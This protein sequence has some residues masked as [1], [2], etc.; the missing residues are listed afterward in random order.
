MPKTGA[1]NPMRILEGS[2][3]LERQEAGLHEAARAALRGWRAPPPG[4]WPSLRW[5]LTLAPLRGLLRGGRRAAAL[6]IDAARYAQGRAGEEALAQV[7]GQ[8]LDD[9]YILLRNYLPPKSAGY[10]GD[11]DGVLVGPPGVI[12]F[13]VKTW[14]GYYRYSGEEWLFRPHPQAGWQPAEKNPTTQARNNAKR[15]ERTLAAAGLGGGHPRIAVRPVI[16]LAGRAAYV[17]VQRP[18]VVPLF[19]LSDRKPEVS[20][21]EQRVLSEATVA[22]VAEALARV[23]RPD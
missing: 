3:Y 11:I 14:R 18:I 7:L 4:F 15:I 20:W 17:D 23:A 13:E 21:L 22:R 19:F 1:A 10:G 8:V 6:E 5:L 16:A 9:R 2:T 12:V